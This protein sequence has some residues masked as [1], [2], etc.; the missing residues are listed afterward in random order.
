M[1][2][3]NIIAYNCLEQ[4]VNDIKKIVK[5]NSLLNLLN[6]FLNSHFKKKSNETK[7]KKI[8]VICV[9]GQIIPD[10]KDGNKKIIK[11]NKNKLFKLILLNLIFKHKKNK[12]GIGK[13]NT[14]YT[15]LNISL[16]FTIL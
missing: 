14:Q 3:K 15:N 10:L 12:Y 16:S 5:K 8:P 1:N 4:T 11:E 9:L 6:C 13:D 7:K 2:Q